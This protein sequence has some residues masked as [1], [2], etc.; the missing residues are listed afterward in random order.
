MSSVDPV[1]F[2]KYIIKKLFSDMDVR[3]KLVPYLDAKY[4]EMDMDN[5]KIVQSYIDFHEEFGSYPKPNEL[6]IALD[7]GTQ[8]SNRIVSKYEIILDIGDD[9]YNK[10]FMLSE[11]EEFFKKKLLAAEVSNLLAIV[12]GKNSAEATAI[13][14]RMTEILSFTFDTNIGLI[15][16]EASEDRIFDAMHAA[17]RVISTGL[18]EIDKMIDGF[19]EKSLILFLGA[20]N[21]G[22][23][24]TQCAFASNCLLQNKKV[25]YVTFEESEDWKEGRGR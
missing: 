12:K 11:V 16:D 2:E 18:T 3:D 22:K 1:F 24:L 7:E 23:T 14:D 10:K 6:M 9:E 8:E 4:F 20:T 17:D 21:V 19:H 15:T 25:L 13:R 5:S